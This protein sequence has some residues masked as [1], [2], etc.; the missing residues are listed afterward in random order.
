[1]NLKNDVMQSMDSE[2]VL[3]ASQLITDNKMI[4]DDNSF[5]T[6]GHQQ[7]MLS[8]ITKLHL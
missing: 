8:L 2:A 5:L 3:A 1:M 7:S 4:L 6:V